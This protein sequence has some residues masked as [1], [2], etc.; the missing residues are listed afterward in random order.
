MEKI[1]IGLWLCCFALNLQACTSTKTTESGEQSGLSF[2]NWAS[3]HTK[4]QLMQQAMK[5]FTISP[6]S[7]S[8]KIGQDD[9]FILT[10]GFTS[11]VMARNVYVFIKHSDQLVETWNLI[12]TQRT[13][14][15][16]VM[17]TSS[18]EAEQVIFQ[19]ETGKTLMILPYDFFKD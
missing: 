5:E 4:A 7:T 18:D 14:A 16:E 19:S 13:T 11:G 2:K 17:I 9:V 3:Y 8:L 12:T 1:K 6:D 10:G 15:K